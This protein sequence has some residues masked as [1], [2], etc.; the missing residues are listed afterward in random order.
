LYG[1]QL[2]GLGEDFYELVVGKEVEARE[3]VTF[4][5]QILFQFFLDLR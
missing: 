3:V 5:F 4:L 2:V 1:I